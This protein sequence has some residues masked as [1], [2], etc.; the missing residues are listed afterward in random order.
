MIVGN[1]NI[2]GDSRTH[3]PMPPSSI[4]MKKPFQ[5]IWRRQSELRAAGRTKVKLQCL[6]RAY[7]LIN[8]DG[9]E[10]CKHLLPRHIADKDRPVRIGIELVVH[11]I[12][13]VTDNHQFRALR[14][15]HWLFQVV[16]KLPI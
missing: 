5:S 6:G 1:A 15:V 8:S 4:K 2:D 13:V 11:G 16:T 12:V 14:D 9:E 3:V 7:V 10:W